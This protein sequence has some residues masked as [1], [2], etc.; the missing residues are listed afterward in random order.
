M[1]GFG[2]QW[3]YY[4]DNE[5]DPYIGTA[6]QLRH[7]FTLNGARYYDPSVG[8]FLTRDP[9]GYAGGINLYTF[10]GNN[11]INYAD[12]SGLKRLSDMDCKELIAEIYKLTGTL[13][14]RYEEMR[15]D[16]QNQFPY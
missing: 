4:T 8:R 3:G 5:V 9:V 16:T 2:G 13:S 7:P 14:Q 15:E 10:C 1:V 12:P 6:P 11:P